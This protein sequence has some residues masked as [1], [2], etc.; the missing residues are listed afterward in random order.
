MENLDKLSDWKIF[1]R[2]L[3]NTIST[4]L[5]SAIEDEFK[6]TKITRVQNVVIPYFI[7]NKDVIVKVI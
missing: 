7:K 3:N 4:D 2:N 6:F 5:I 1:N